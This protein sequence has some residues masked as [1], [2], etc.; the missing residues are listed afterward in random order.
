MKGRLTLS[1]VFALLL[2]GNARAFAQVPVPT[3]SPDPHTYSDPAMTFT[4]PSDALL[5]GRQTISLDQ[6]GQDLQLIATWVLHAGQE[7]ARTIQISM[8]AY[9]GPPD[10]WEAQFE[11]QTHSS[12]EGTLIRNKTPM[13]LLNGMPAYF[14]EIAYGSG[15]GA[16]KEFAIVWADGQRGV[17]L[18]ETTRMGDAT[19]DEAKEVLKQVTA[20]RYPLEEP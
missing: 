5:I 6:L 10:Q 2:A 16:R 8:E 20:V 12:Q 13:A 7:D 3:P 17:V 9:D 14:V 18:S 19:S 1:L 4:A 11:S 15:F